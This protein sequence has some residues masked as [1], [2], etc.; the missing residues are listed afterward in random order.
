MLFDRDELDHGGGAH[1]IDALQT[2][3]AALTTYICT[4]I[5]RTQYAAHT[6]RLVIAT[7]GVNQ[8]A[9]T[10]SDDVASQLKGGAVNQTNSPEG[11]PSADECSSPNQ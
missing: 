6:I 2:C 4:F 11:K 5:E 9:G 3:T 10:E 8:T 1:L 7:C